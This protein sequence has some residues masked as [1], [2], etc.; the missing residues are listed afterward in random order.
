M[1][2]KYRKLKMVS[3][4]LGPTDQRERETEK[5]R[6]KERIMYREDLFI[7][8]KVIKLTAGVML[9]LN[10]KKKKRFSIISF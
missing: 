3:A 8:L 9:A 1:R 10:C 6:K 5:K 4:S 7:P 2:L